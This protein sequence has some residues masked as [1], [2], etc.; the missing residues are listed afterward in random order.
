MVPNGMWQSTP[1]APLVLRSEGRFA[2][3]QRTPGMP[4]GPAMALVFP[5]Y[6]GISLSSM[7]LPVV[8]STM[9]LGAK[10]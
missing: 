10:R 4:I 8:Y 2:E 5:T 1:G 3:L 7:A 9:P 6:V